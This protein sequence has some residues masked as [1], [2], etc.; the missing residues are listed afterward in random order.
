MEKLRD[1]MSEYQDRWNARAALDASTGATAPPSI[2][3]DESLCR[4][5]V[6]A[7]LRCDAAAAAATTVAAADGAAGGVAAPR[8]LGGPRGG[9]AVAAGCEGYG[10]AASFGLELEGET[11]RDAMADDVGDDA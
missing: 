1:F 5:S 11:G 8:G 7:A 6:Y 10:F 2:T 4:A 9:A 3:D